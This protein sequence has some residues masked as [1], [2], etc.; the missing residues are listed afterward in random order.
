MASKSSIRHTIYDAV[1]EIAR[2][3]DV[4]FFITEDPEFY[5]KISR[6]ERIYRKWMGFAKGDISIWHLGILSKFE[7]KP[8][9][10][11]VRPY[12]IHSTEEEGVFEQHIFPEYFTSQNIGGGSAFGRTIMEIVRYDSLTVEQNEQLVDFC[13]Q[14]IGKPFPKSLRGESLT[15]ILGLPNLFEPP[16][17]YSCHTLV[18]AAFDRVGVN[19]PHHLEASPF[20]NVGK[21]LGRP[22]WHKRE[23]VNIKYPYL[24]D[25]HLYKDPRFKSIMTLTYDQCSEEIFIQRYPQKFSWNPRLA[26]IYHV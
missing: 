18:Y 7:K 13:R 26:E 24:R 23:K 8:K 10:S 17:Q 4:C 20:F 5:R 16:E 22:L 15:Y 12:I 11:Q 3:G 2:L 25:H 1:G 19:F 21:Y 9:S 14:Q 6:Y